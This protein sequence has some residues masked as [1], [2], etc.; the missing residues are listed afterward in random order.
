MRNWA[1][2]RKNRPGGINGS[3]TSQTGFNINNAVLLSK[4]GYHQQDTS[5]ANQKPSKH[6]CLKPE[7]EPT[8]STRRPP[9]PAPSSYSSFQDGFLLG[10]AAGDARTQCSTAWKLSAFFEAAKQDS[11][12]SQPIRTTELTAEAV[13]FNSINKR[14]SPSLQQRHY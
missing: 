1:K 11:C 5:F 10:C 7:M 14:S 6:D 12:S 4:H 3:R 2:S 13:L 8:A 9:L